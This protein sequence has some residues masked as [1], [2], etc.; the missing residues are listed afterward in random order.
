VSLAVFWIATS[1]VVN[2][3]W[4]FLDANVVGR[5][6]VTT[7]DMAPALLPGDWLV[8]DLR[9]YRSREPLPGEL[10]LVRDPDAVDPAGRARVAR[11]VAVGGDRVEL[12]AHNLYVNG[13]RVTEG[14]SE[15]Y[16]APD[17]E[18]KV[19]FEEQLGARRF[20]VLRDNGDVVFRRPSRYTVEPGHYFLLG[21]NR[22]VSR[23]SRAYGALPRAALAGRLLYR[24]V[25]LETGTPRMAWS[26]IGALP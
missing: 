10:V 5:F 26:R 6:K 24:I 20:R 16:T 9:A 19:A 13:E 18:A 12:R 2:A 3:A 22:D 23:D 7:L 8:V 21:D 14:R 25:A 4:L 15:P 17:G 1:V 11:V